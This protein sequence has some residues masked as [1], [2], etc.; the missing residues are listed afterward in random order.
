M[1]DFARWIVAGTP[2][3]GFS[4]GAFLDAYR[5]N[6]RAATDT[7]LEVSAIAP[8]VK[9]LARQGWTG[10]AT[11][12]L[13]TLDG[14]IDSSTQKRGDYPKTT[15]A[16][17]AALLR[18]APQFRQI[19]VEIA[20]FRASTQERTRLIEIRTVANEPVQWVQPA[21][22]EPEPLDTTNR[23]V[24]ASSPD[25]V[26]ETPLVPQDGSDGWDG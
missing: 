1:A 25:G 23:A 16:L 15:K 21:P 12:L 18:L 19:G 5:S 7:L 13:K 24:R 10:T 17:H 26:S 8:A 11:D 9:A 14:A 3:L 20:W 6:R 4:G 22:S 2:E